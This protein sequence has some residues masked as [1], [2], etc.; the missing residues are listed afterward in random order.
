MFKIEV[1]GVFMSEF[2]SIMKKLGSK[3][4]GLV[5]LDENS[6]HRSKTTAWGSWMSPSALIFTTQRSV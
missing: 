5:D 2:W 4:Y 3:V 6:P 1:E